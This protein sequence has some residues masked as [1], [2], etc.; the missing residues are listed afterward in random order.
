[1][2]R[3]VFIPLSVQIH[4]SI[5]MGEWAESNVFIQKLSPWI[6]NRDCLEALINMNY[7]MLIYRYIYIHIYFKLY[8]YIY[9]CLVGNG[10]PNHYMLLFKLYISNSTSLARRIRFYFLIDIPT[11]LKLWWFIQ[12]CFFLVTKYDTRFLFMIFK[13]KR[14]QKVHVYIP[15][16]KVTI[17]I[18]TLR[19]KVLMKPNIKSIWAKLVF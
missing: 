10:F 15:L 19:F 4:E 3:F 18:L 8:R 7:Q 9:Q 17:I 14:S 6:L 1:M 16:S 5:L 13:N 2:L 11:Y 12:F